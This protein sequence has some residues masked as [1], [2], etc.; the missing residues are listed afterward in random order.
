[1]HQHW[2]DNKIDTSKLGTWMT[3]MVPTAVATCAALGEGGS[4]RGVS[5][6]ILM[7]WSISGT[8]YPEMNIGSNKFRKIKQKNIVSK[9]HIHRSQA[10]SET[11]YLVHLFDNTS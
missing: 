5:L 1:L 10:I 2:P 9:Q 11:L 8:W 4:P 6:A 7:L 3:T